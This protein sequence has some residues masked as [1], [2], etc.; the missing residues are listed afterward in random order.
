MAEP[1]TPST[2]KIYLLQKL[3]ETILS[4]RYKPG[5]RLNESL[6]AREFKISRI[7]VREALLQL[8]ESGLV[9]NRKRKGMF[10]TLLSEE[11]TQKI[12][13]VRLVL[14]TEALKLARRRMTPETAAALTALVDKMEGWDGTLSE[15]AALDLE[16]HRTIWE[17]SGNAYLAKVLDSL[18]ASLFTYKTLEH[19]SYDLRRWRLNHH[20]ALLDVVLGSEEQDIQGALLMHLRMA[21]KDPERYSSLARSQSWPA[22]TGKDPEITRR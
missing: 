10:V 7:P 19:I 14:E 13:S 12:N 11:D 2:L 4:G 5:D 18:V 9:T 21:Y 6:I 20:R 15:A 3:R 22:R 1:A 16:F 8:Q 17:A